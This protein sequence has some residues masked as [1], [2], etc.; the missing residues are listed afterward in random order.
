MMISNG[1]IKLII[2]FVLQATSDVDPHKSNPALQKA[3]TARKR[4]LKMP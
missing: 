1:T 3:E 4:L 2:G